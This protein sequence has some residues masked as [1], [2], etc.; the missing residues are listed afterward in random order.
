MQYENFFEVPGHVQPLL[1]PQLS[2]EQVEKLNKFYNDW[3]MDDIEDWDYAVEGM[4]ENIRTLIAEEDMK[5]SE[6]VTV[7][8]THLTLPTILLV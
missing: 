5:L 2:Q 3:D 6:N 4:S 7:S 8:Y 1:Q